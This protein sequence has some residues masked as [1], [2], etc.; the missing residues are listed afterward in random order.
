MVPLEEDIALEIET[1]LQGRAWVNALPYK[2][3]LAKGNSAI[4]FGPN[5][6][7]LYLNDMFT[8]FSLFLKVRPSFLAQILAQ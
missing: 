4:V 5:E 7:R 1:L 8:K 6:V 2:K 3:E